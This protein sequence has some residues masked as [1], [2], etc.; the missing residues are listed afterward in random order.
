VGL[1]IAI[2][3]PALVASLWTGAPRAQEL[4]IRPGQED[5]VLGLFAPYAPGGAVAAGWRLGGV[6][7]RPDCISVTLQA[8]DERT[9]TLTLRHPARAP[10][11][12][13]RTKSFAVVPD[14]AQGADV[15]AARQAVVEAISRNDEG[16]FWGAA[17]YQPTPDE[18]R[19]PTLDEHRSPPPHEDGP[20]VRFE[21]G[22]R[23]W[24][25]ID[26]MVVI[27]LLVVLSGLVAAR[28]LVREPRWMPLALAGIVAGGVLVRL[29][30]SPATFLGAWPWS[31]LY[32]N[33][34]AVAN[35][36]VLEALSGMVGHPFY[37]TDV[38]LWTNFAYAAAMPLVLFGHATYLLREPRAGLAAAFA[39]ALLPQHI[40]FSLC[41]D[42]FVGS[43][44][45]T[46]L[47][48]SLIHGWLRDPSR[49][50]R[51]L[52][53][54][55]LPFVLYPGYL[56]RPLNILFIVVYVAAILALH[57]E[58]APLWR[59]VVALGIVLGVGAAAVAT[60]VTINQE[61]LGA[62]S[63]L[64]WLGN[65][66]RVLVSPEL[67]VIDDPTRTPFPVLLLAI[68]G[69]VLTWRGGE[70]RLVL[71]LAGWLLLF[72]AAHAFVVQA[73]MQPRYH[74][75]LVVPFL[76]LGAC[77]VP[78][79]AARWRPWLWVAAGL[80]LVAPWLHRGFIQDQSYTEMAE[81]AMVREA[82]DLVPE[83]CTVLEYTR[84]PREVNELRFSRIGAHASPART[85]RF[86]A[87][88]VFPDGEVT[89]GEPALDGLLREP[90]ACLYFYE[91]LA[92]S[93]RLE[94]GQT[95]AKQCTDLRER[96]QAEPILQTAAEVKLYDT[97][98][99]LGRPLEVERVWFRLSRARLGQSPRAA[100]TPD[101]TSTRRSPR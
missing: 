97:G 60:F 16:T 66:F 5:R 67:M 39:I 92:C 35:G 24:V 64:D 2:L 28:L 72:L 45:L 80:I 61:T 27:A 49:L 65:I 44:T 46:S 82:R 69:G 62:A 59:R 74:L 29:G 10:G 8:A 57:R 52:L 91:G 95:Y 93:I 77:A 15:A 9:S 71:F 55:A 23:T 36:E 63:Q 26:G 79:L 11:G 89:P 87:I 78:R 22:D 30:L 37:L 41:E 34:R 7:I 88:G 68:L 42:G 51:W 81:L 25:P 32:P 99:A 53:L 4:V 1:P 101:P 21:W 38:T 6:A 48:F 100:I 20:R 47:A 94:P 18:H 50:V 40:R 56:L 84:S 19:Q 17:T 3:L 85:E 58:T 90:P 96:L 43:L 98:S 31:R 86:H 14:D 54:V 12:A 73:S 76:L 75:H 70:R 13:V 33:V 83:G